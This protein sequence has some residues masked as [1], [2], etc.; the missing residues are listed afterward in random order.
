MEKWFLTEKVLSQRKSLHLSSVTDEK[1][2]PEQELGE[3]A[4]LYISW[5]LDGESSFRTEIY[6]QYL[7]LRYAYISYSVLENNLS[8]RGN[9]LCITNKKPLIL[10]DL[11]TCV[12]IRI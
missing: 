3:I 5:A 9:H 10:R 8:Q 11:G 2:S 12:Q 6:I 1:S 7:C 4:S